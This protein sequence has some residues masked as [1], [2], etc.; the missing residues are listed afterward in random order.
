[1]LS[2]LEKNVIASIQG[3][4]DVVERPYAAI[5]RSLEI[6][7]ETL[8]K[9]LQALCD[10]GVIRRFGATIRHQKSG[11]SANAMVAWR[12]AENRIDAVGETMAA[13]KQVSHCYHRNPAGDWP[14][15]LYTMV[16]A[17]DEATC[18]ETAR[19]MA[20]AAGV[21]Q[22]ALLFSVRELKKTSMQY[23]SNEFDE[24]DIDD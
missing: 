10:R 12:V 17:R 15:N 18:I 2:D 4:I 14:Y 24:D 5:A 11:Y 20:A 13:F 1:M 3:D 9:T 19:Q 22:Y 16:H 7:E 23:F 8:L 21:E 6:S